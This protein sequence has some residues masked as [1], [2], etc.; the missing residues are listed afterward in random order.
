MKLFIAFITFIFQVNI[1]ISQT[2]S[3]QNPSF[4]GTPAPHITPN[5]WGICMP[6]V[7]PDTQPN[8]WGVNLSPTDGDSYLGMCH[9]QQP[10]WQEGAS[11]QLLNE[12]TGD[13]EPMQ[14]GVEYQFEIDVSDHPTSGSWI[15]SGPME[16]RVW[17]GFSDC[18][19]TELLWSSGDVPNFVW[20]TY[21]VTFT[22]TMNF[23][24]IMFQSNALTNETGY[25]IIDNMSYIELACT[26]PQIV[27][28]TTDVSCPGFSDGVI[29]ITVSGVGG[30]TYNWN[31]NDTTED[32]TNLTA[33]MYNVTVTDS[34]G[35]SKDTSINL[36]QPAPI[37]QISIET[38][39]YNGYNISCIGYNNG[40]IDLT[41]PNPNEYTYLWNGTDTT[42][43]IINLNAGLH[44]LIVT[45]L[46]G[47]S[48]DT[49]FTL[50]EPPPIISQHQKSNYNGY[51]ISCFDS[52]DG[53]IE[54]FLD[55]GV[56]PFNYTWSNNNLGSSNQ[57]LSAGV[58]FLEVVDDNNCYYFESFNLDEPN[59]IITSI[60]SLNDFNGFDIS[61]YGNNDAELLL[62]INGGNP[63]YTI[64]WSSGHQTLFLGEVGA[65][66]YIVNVSDINGCL[67]S[68]SIIISEPDLLA[69]TI[70]SVYD[71]NGYD[72]S[73]FGESDGAINLD[74][75]GGVQPYNYSWDEGSNT[76]DINNLIANQYSV[77]VLDA[78]NC[79]TS[80]SII[81]DEPSSFQT[82]YSSSNYNGYGV[83]CFDSSD[84]W[85]D[86]TTTGSVP[87]YTFNWSNGTFS[88]D[89]T[90]ITSGTFELIINDLNSCE[91]TL[92]FD[93][94]QPTPL[95]TDILSLNN[96]NGFDVSCNGSFDGSIKLNNSGGVS[97]YGILWSTGDTT[98]TIS[99]L[100][101]AEYSVL[102]ID[103]NGCQDENSFTLS[104]PDLLASTIQSVYDYNGYDISCFGEADGAIDLD[105]DGGVQPYN[106]SWSNGM[107]S[108]DLNQINEGSYMVN[109]LDANNC[110]TS[111]Q[112]SL[113][114]PS[115]LNINHV[116][117]NFNNFNL[118]C[119]GSNDGFISSSVIGSVPPY[120]YSWSNGE[121]TP[122]I[123]NLSSGAYNLLVTDNNGCFI[124]SS[125]LL[126][127]PNDFYV[128]L[129]VSNDTC[130][131]GVGG[132]SVYI[133]PQFNNYSIS[134][135][136]G[137]ISN[138][139]Y[140]LNNGIY[141]VIVTDPYNCSKSYSFEIG[142]VGMPNASFSINP[143]AENN[144]YSI[145]SNLK[146]EDESIDSES[147]IVSWNWDFGDGNF[148][149]EKNT[150]HFYENRGNY[151]VVLEIEN[152]FGCIDTAQINVKI[153]A[154]SAYIPNTFTPT[155][156]TK[157]DIF[158]IYGEEI[159][160][161]ELSIFDRWGRCIFYSLNQGWNGIDQ[162]YGNKCAQG[163]YIYH[164]VVKD[165]FDQSHEFIGD[166]SLIE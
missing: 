51:N 53:W 66:N 32:L 146:F 17:G 81:L 113:I 4:E 92:S 153:G 164:F 137:E 104:E 98:Y 5:L 102:V 166:I 84:G 158:K 77:N 60:Q 76:E 69:S 54:V 72:I 160:E 152:S 124:T 134:W 99:S 127:E 154:F 27:I 86:Q 31:N 3:V 37:S 148:S 163:V 40:S 16:L 138:D 156:D 29:D 123:N 149:N 117:S 150:F 65:G 79:N 42:E 58:Y 126:T 159:L 116:L 73:C 44:E 68:D 47:C 140:S 151:N 121:D 64:N 141:D 43:D 18:S 162:K 39:D 78:N 48:I 49:S 136:N 147:T 67:T 26:P 135:S 52:T 110:N 142:D 7:T 157:N 85:I 46:N 94:T 74:V 28:A 57:N 61:C 128:S 106:F 101:A 108:E 115:A 59:Q 20:T 19:E 120:S 56:A 100:G 143:I 36:Y 63:D 118:S 71:Y 62:E 10:Y 8:I 155:G 12:N 112:L 2:L 34:I 14:A 25:L 13:P 97:P 107:S 75:Y 111:N 122:N 131:R 30:Y 165:I 82:T 80:N 23:S 130:G 91:S 144:F 90:S 114:E 33:G 87:P 50:T 21:T 105:V 15:V 11:Q 24:H 1:I 38:S 132:A 89:L 119:F 88:E 129:G 93:L 45:D 9:Q 6:G 95:F 96:Y 133:T 139:I 83:S 22:P 145:N 125:H 35:C 103:E 161:Y 70:Q 41:I 109:I 55:G